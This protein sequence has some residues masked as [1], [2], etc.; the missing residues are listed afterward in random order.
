MNVSGKLYLPILLSL[1]I[2][3]LP[4][5]P[6]RLFAE[7][8]EP[9]QGI[10]LAGRESAMPIQDSEAETA[11]KSLLVDEAE[12][13]VMDSVPKGT[14]QLNMDALNAGFELGENCEV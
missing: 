1:I 3:L 10:E 7:L 6:S 4:G 13:A 11:E 2:L 8:D 9:P 5:L 12:M 14:E